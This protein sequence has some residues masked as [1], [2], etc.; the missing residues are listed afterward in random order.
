MIIASIDIGTNTII[1]LIAKI[2]IDNE[3]ISPLCNEQRIP[4]LG[5]GL[6]PGRPI[7]KEKINELL[8]ILEEY[9][10]IIKKYDCEKI[11]VTGTNALRITSNNN[12]IKKMV[13]EKL[14][15]DINVV[16]GEDEAELTFK[17][18]VFQFKDSSNSL[19]ID[20][21]GGST[22][23]IFGDMKK[24]IFKQSYQ[25]GVVSAKEK[26][27]KHAPPLQNEITNL[28]NEM[29]SIFGEL[30]KK[31]FTVHR[32]IA[33]AGTPTTLAAI[34][35]NLREYDEDLL[36]GHILSY[37]EIQNLILGLSNLSDIEILKKF[38]AVVNGRED[39]ILNGA[40]ILL[41]IM[42]LLGL[43]EV[44]VSTKGL[45]YGAVCKELFYF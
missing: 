33:I 29:D 5:K 22:E 6:A 13:K 2:D 20:I 31:S 41:H 9:N 11:I 24:V 17:G 1:L 14:N 10:K 12:E 38:K 36:E 26:Y 7:L 21:G 19:V 23:I 16:S 35:L 45:R 25:L 18:A 4:R 15:L 27:L 43:N 3:Q 8:S 42:K 44:I 37:N 32:A 30:K 34:K 40:I 28:Q 39:V